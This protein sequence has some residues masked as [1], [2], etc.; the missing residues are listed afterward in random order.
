MDDPGNEQPATGSASTDPQAV[1]RT[2]GGRVYGRAHEQRDAYAEA[3]VDL[4]EAR[5]RRSARSHQNL[6]ARNT[7]VPAD[8]STNVLLWENNVVDPLDEALRTVQ[9]VDL[10]GLLADIRLRLD[11]EKRGTA[12]DVGTAVHT[13]IAAVAPHAAQLHIVE[14]TELVLRLS[15]C[16]CSPGRHHRANSTHVAGFAAEYLRGPWR[17]ARPWR[18]VEAEHRVATGRGDLVWR[19]ESTGAVLFDEI[20]T[21]AVARRTCD[22]EWLDQATGYAMAGAIEYG[23]HFLGVRIV[24]LGSMNVATCVLPDTSRRLIAPSPTE[25]LRARSVR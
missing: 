10:D 19:N 17:P 9:H 6:T 7:G 8:A 16:V 20:K 2:V 21:T 5:A 14:L 22:P 24:P 25:P 15:R 12:A 11:G 23:S 13:V 18:C 1:A 4:D 3:P